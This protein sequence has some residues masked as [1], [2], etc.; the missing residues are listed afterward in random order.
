MIPISATVY[1]WQNDLLISLTWVFVLPSSQGH[2]K[3]FYCGGGGVWGGIKM[4]VTMVDQ[5]QKIKKNTG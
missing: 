2:R 4:S 5:G 1:S 3:L